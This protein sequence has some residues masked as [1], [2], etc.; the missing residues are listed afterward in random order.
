MKSLKILAL[1]VVVLAAVGIAGW[2]YVNNKAHI[3]VSKGNPE[4]EL[5]A[6]QLFEDFLNNESE[7]HASYLGKIGVI[8]SG[9]SYIEESDNMLVLV[10]VL[11]TGVFGDEGIRCTLD[12]IM[13]E[14]AKQLTAGV[15]LSIKG[16][17]KGFNGVDVIFENC[18]IL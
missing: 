5:P 18:I 6:S 3:N 12:P 16:L 13:H 1:A 8:T 14:R 15:E 7:A 9:L 10:F 17:C 11:N 2:W 4:F